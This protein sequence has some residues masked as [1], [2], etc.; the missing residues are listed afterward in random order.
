MMRTA[1]GFTAALVLALVVGA[2]PAAAQIGSTIRSA[3]VD[4]DGNP[5]EGVNIEFVYK[6]ETRV[7][8]IKKTASDKK[9]RWIR[10]GL[11]QGQWLITFTKEGFKPITYETWTGGDALAELPP[12]TMQPAAAGKS[13]PTSAAEVEKAAK[14][15]ELMKRLGQQYTAGVEAMNV[16]DYASAE[17]AFNAVLAERPGLAAAHHN[18]GYLRMLQNDAAGAE[19]QFRLAIEN[20]K[21]EAMDSYMALST[22]LSSQNKGAEAFEL[23]AGVKE[24]FAADGRFQYAFGVVASNSGKNAEAE[25]AFSRAAELDPANVESLYQLGTLAVG[26]NDIPA[27]ISS[28]EK[29][30]AAAPPEAAN[31]VTAKALIEA[32]RK[33]AKK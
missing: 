9:G 11:R 18:L 5:V 26:R 21:A 22:L 2:Q 14:E 13:S 27:A 10:S 1:V 15:Q 16:K 28:L 33:K 3:I 24:T 25:E 20:G 31:V 17:A 12:F 32:L 7:P 23:L 30:V 4:K 29:Y 6:G 8:I 19:A